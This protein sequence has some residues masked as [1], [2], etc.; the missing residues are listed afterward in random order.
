MPIEIQHGSPALDLSALQMASIIG[1]MEGLRETQDRRTESGRVRR[2]EGREEAQ[3]AE[4]QRANRARERQSQTALAAQAFSD[5]AGTLRDYSRQ[6][7]AE[8]AQKQA[9]DFQKIKWEEE[10]ARAKFELDLEMASKG[11]VRGVDP[12]SDAGLQLA[13]LKSQNRAI[14]KAYQAGELH[15]ESQYLPLKRQIQD[16][17]RTIEENN[18]FYRPP[19]PSAEELVRASVVPDLDENGK[20]RGFWYQDVRAGAVGVR[21]QALKTERAK[22]AGDDLTYEEKKRLDAQIKA[23]YEGRANETKREQ[24]TAKAE[25][26]ERR[27]SEA[28][29]R[30]AAEDDTAA[31]LEREEIP[32]TPENADYIR[33]IKQDFLKSRF[34]EAGLDFDADYR[35]TLDAG[36]RSKLWESLSGRDQRYLARTADEIERLMAEGTPESEGKAKAKQDEMDE[37]I[38]TQYEILSRQGTL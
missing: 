28:A 25:T 15:F 21:Y 31:Y 17:I 10:K 27:K 16:G 8:Q 9:L 19:G 33:G 30:K 32:R 12:T 38:Q 34:E 6:K 18:L 26:A 23:E 36:E 20:E 5:L 13:E 35:D 7:A 14:D 22:A 3:I 2:A 29:A 1:M 4:Q 37:F 24:E 11:F